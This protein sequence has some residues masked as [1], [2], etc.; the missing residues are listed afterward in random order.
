MRK[1]WGARLYAE[2]IKVKQA[3]WKGG[4]DYT[5][6]PQNF[7]AN[8]RWRDDWTLTP[9][10]VVKP[11]EA[12]PKTKPVDNLQYKEA[13]E[14]ADF[15]FHTHQDSAYYASIGKCSVEDS[16]KGSCQESNECH[17]EQYPNKFLY[18]FC[19]VGKP[20]Y[21]EYKRLE[22]L[23]KGLDST[24]D[25]TMKELIEINHLMKLRGSACMALNP[26]DSYDNDEEWRGLCDATE[27]ME[28]NALHLFK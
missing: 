22:I 10:P 6:Q 16:C 7:I 2:N 8:E 1:P 12:K 18:D 27:E 11:K 9:L 4:K 13:Y 15:D 26:D 5:I 17:Y 20:L 28:R 14:K 19:V 25:A 3:T 21:Y 23:Y 24:G